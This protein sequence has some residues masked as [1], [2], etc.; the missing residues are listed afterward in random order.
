MKEITWWGSLLDDAVKTLD[1]AKEKGEEG[2]IV[3]QGEKIYTGITLDEAYLKFTGHTKE[4]FEKILEK[5]QAQYNKEQQEERE[6]AVRMMS[7][8]ITRGEKVIFPERHER[9]QK[10]VVDQVQGIYNGTH[11]K[12]VLNILEALNAGATKEEIDLLLHKASEETEVVYHV[13]GYVSEFCSVPLGI[14]LAEDMYK[15]MI[16]HGKLSPALQRDIDN[17][18]EELRIL[19]EKYNKIDNN[20]LS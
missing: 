11:V 16:C 1:R 3:F 8:W 13:I 15:K 12:H 6:E 18:R 10:Y 4:E 9:W 5:K 7:E 19:S 2:Y 20:T 17:D 14:D